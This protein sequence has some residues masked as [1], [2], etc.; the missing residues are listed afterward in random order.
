MN[1]EQQLRAELSELQTKLADP[2]IYSDPSYP[3]LAKRQSE[4]ETVV[5]LFDEREKILKERAEAKE[6]T[7]SGDST[8]EDMAMHEVSDLTDKLAKVDAA[9]TEALV[10]KDP[11]DDRD[12]ILE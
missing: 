4:L 12:A 6:L 1:S 11:N 9:L 2:G 3:K 5:G 8:M 10:P 7:H